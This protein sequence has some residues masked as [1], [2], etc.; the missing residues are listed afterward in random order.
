MGRA[1]EQV[2]QRCHLSGA[3]AGSEGI[4]SSPRWGRTGSCWG[5]AWAQAKEESLFPS[6][7]SKELSTVTVAQVSQA[8]SGWHFDAKVLP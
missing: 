3:K 5:P 1:W 7:S 4:A 2:G 6:H 8:M